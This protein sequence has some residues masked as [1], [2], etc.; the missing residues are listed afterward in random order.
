MNLWVGLSVRLSLRISFLPLTFAEDELKEFAN[1][2]LE[3]F[4]NPFIDHK[5]L[6][7][8]LNSISKF[9]TRVQPSLT[10]YIE[11]YN[12]L[13]EHLVFSLAALILFYRGREI[14]DNR[15]IGLRDGQEYPVN[16]QKEILE[17]FK[18]IWVSYESDN[19]LEDLIVK[20]LGRQ[21][22]WERDLNKLEGLT[23]RVYYYLM[24][25]L[26][27]GMKKALEQLLR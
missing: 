15:L 16:D 9:K 27:K 3:R 20:V 1:D 5:W 8:S 24:E 26:N 17:F 4:N 7:I 11:R 23:D 14:E 21:E 13:P 10:G 2:I 18:E 6:D 12:R 25:I 19:N 22:F